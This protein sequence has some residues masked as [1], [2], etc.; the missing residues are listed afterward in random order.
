MFEIKVIL[1]NPDSKEKME[2]TGLVDT[3]ATLTVIPRRVA[4]SLKILPKSTANVM[5]AGGPIEIDISSAEI[6]VSGKRDVVRIAISDVIDKVLIGVTT[7][8]IL[9]LA[10][11]PISGQLKESTYLLY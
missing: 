1:G 7:L 3:G 4:N 8:E 10:V 6:E 11:D 2:V 5:T 9:G